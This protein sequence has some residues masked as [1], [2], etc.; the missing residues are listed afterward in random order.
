MFEG[1]KW[2][3]VPIISEFHIF[4]K[5]ISFSG[6]F[7]FDESTRDQEVCC[8]N[9]TAM[10]QF[11]VVL[12]YIVKLLRTIFNLYTIS[13]VCISYLLCTCRS[14]YLVFL[15]KKKFHYVHFNIHLSKLK[16]HFCSIRANI[17]T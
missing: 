1:T 7:A 4:L 17:T 5:N 16:E 14:V 3:Q 10:H 8:P 12:N 15:I 2:F 13:I 11:A 9:C 6:Y